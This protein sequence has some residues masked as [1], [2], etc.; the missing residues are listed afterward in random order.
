MGNIG[1]GIKPLATI[2]TYKCS[3]HEVEEWVQSLLNVTAVAQKQRGGKDAPQVNATVFSLKTSQKFY[4]FVAIL[5]EIALFERTNNDEELSIFSPEEMN[6]AGKLRPHVW[7][8]L[9]PF[10]YSKDDK[11]AFHSAN[12]RSIFGISGETGKY[13]ASLCS[14]K[15]ER[16]GDNTIV[17]CLLD[18]LR[19]FHGMVKGNSNPADYAI[20]IESTQHNQG[21][22]YTYTFQ[23][24]PKSGKNRRRAD[25]QAEVERAMYNSIRRG[26]R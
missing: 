17:T 21:S 13:L 3:T 8:A 16:R 11:Q 14:P 6:G 10:I 19:I 25:V 5:P 22:D 9:S 26:G 20:E 4:P 2:E 23:K 24:V 7:A 1:N 18:P 12:A 15:V